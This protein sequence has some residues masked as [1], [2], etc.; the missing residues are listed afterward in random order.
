[1]SKG[2]KVWIQQHKQVCLV[3]LISFGILLLGYVLCRFIFF[4]LHGMKE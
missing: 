1:M 2:F 4:E 3:H